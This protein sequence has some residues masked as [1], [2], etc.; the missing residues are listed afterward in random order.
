VVFHPKLRFFFFIFFNGYFCPLG[1]GYRS[2][3]KS[4]IESWVIQPPLNHPF[5][6]FRPSKGCFLALRVL[7]VNHN[8]PSRYREPTPPSKGP[9]SSLLVKWP[10]SQ[11]PP[12]LKHFGSRPCRLMRT[13]RVSH[14]PNIHS[15]WISRL[16]TPSTTSLPFCKAEHRPSMIFD[17]GIE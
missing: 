16:A 7:T 10:T 13:R 6:R 14:W 15:P 5:F 8:T 4:P 2:G 9:T 11:D 12:V 1:G 17:K 3:D